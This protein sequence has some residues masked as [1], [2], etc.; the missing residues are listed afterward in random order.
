MKTVGRVALLLCLTSLLW[1]QAGVS[2]VSGT[3]VGNAEPDFAAIDAYV[4]A[5]MK[6]LRL[7]GL[8]LGIVHGDRIVHLKGFGIADPSRRPV[9]PQTPFIIGSTSKSF[10][11]LAIMQ[12]V[13]EG[14]IGL[15]TPV[16]H[17]LPW[18][19][20]ADPDGSARITVRQL[21]HQTSGL[22]TKSGRDQA[23][24]PSDDALE[25]RGRSFRNVP[26]A[27]PVGKTYQYSGANY[28]TLG[29]IVQA[30]SGQSYE[31]YV[32][33]HIFTPLEMRRSYASQL[34]AQQ[35]GMAMG[36]RF[37]FGMP[38]AGNL[39]FNRGSL[40]QGYLIS[41]AEDMS[42]YL[43]AQLNGGRYKTASILSSTGITA[44]H[45]PPVQ[46]GMTETS[47]AMGWKVGPINGIPTVWHDGSVFNFHANMVLIPAGRWGI[48]VLK[49]AYNSPDEFTGT[50]RLSG[51]AAGITTLLS[52]GQPPAVPSNIALYLFYG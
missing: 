13:E 5:Q 49:N 28:A 8:A 23:S 7:P 6:D 29:M 2:G 48:V 36:Y 50:N 26:L 19:R 44:M 27:Q 33:Q 17:Y 9:T 32:K 51:I 47:Y 39:P 24:T 14:R 25:Q 3:Q 37:W 16:Q 22:S 10:T 1:F 34:E 4:V 41:S 15:D 31:A 30:V 38:V 21:L 45:Q 12:L 52:G 42:H 43:I 20:V 18:F 46:A 40:P 11:A 35:N